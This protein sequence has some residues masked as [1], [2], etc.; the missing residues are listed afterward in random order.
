[1]YPNHPDAEFPQHKM[2]KHLDLRSSAIPISGTEFS[3]AHRKKKKN[4]DIIE[5][6]IGEDEMN[7][8][9]IE[10]TIKN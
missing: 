3:G 10:N 6:N 9:E 8:N 5:I 4:N 2:Q 1:M 7:S